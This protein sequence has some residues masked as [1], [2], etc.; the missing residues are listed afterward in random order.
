MGK[1][2]SFARLWAFTSLVHLTL[3]MFV[4]SSYPLPHLLLMTPL[5]LEVNGGAR[6]MAMSSMSKTC[7]VFTV[8]PFLPQYQ[9]PQCPTPLGRSDCLAHEYFT[10]CYSSG[11]NSLFSHSKTKNLSR[12]NYVCRTD[13]THVKTHRLDSLPG[14]HVP[15]LDQAVPGMGSGG[16]RVTSSV[17]G[18]GDAGGS[19]GSY[20]SS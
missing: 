15:G 18:Y 19:C 10:L 6:D 2:Q 1:L 20:G 9:T 8:Y 13:A 12:H 16:S 14:T 4:N 3:E 17:Q 11:Q 5:I 7:Y